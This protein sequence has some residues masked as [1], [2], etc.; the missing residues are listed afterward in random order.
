MSGHKT[1]SYTSI[2]YRASFLVYIEDNF[3]KNKMFSKNRF[4]ISVALL[5]LTIGV[6]TENDNTENGNEASDE[7]LETCSTDPNVSGCTDS[8]SAKSRSK[9]FIRLPL[10]TTLGVQSRLIIPQIPV[11][12]ST[13]SLL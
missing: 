7:N 2:D 5:C 9:R 6:L 3:V 12:S 8:G 1:Y 13:F 4:L 10:L 11:T